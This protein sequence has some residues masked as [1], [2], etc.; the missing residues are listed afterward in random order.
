MTNAPDTAILS[1]VDSDRIAAA[2]GAAEAHANGEIVTVITRTSDSYADVAL[3]WSVLIAGVALL[4]LTIDPGF[5][6]GLVDRMLGLWAHRWTPHDVLGLALFVASVTF[7]A[8]WVI[9]LWRRL[10]LALTP[11][12]IK[13]A[14]VRARA[15]AAFRL[16]AQGR[17]R[18][19]TGVVIYLSMAE[20]RAEII[21]DATIA[22]KVT[23]EV[24]GDAM[25]AMLAHFRDDRVADGVIAGVAAVGVVL[26]AH[27][28]REDKPGN[29]LPDGP[30]EL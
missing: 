30:I 16:S 12:P 25:H 20:R 29:E 11:G 14:R 9:L 27:F 17:T 2:V 6:L 3:V 22:G 23:P 28:P 18:G 5:F 26:A 21:A 15:R 1:P 24:W 8:M 19:A 13:T 7:A 4:A 10:R